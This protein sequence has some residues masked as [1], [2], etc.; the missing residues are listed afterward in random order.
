MCYFFPVGALQL[1]FRGPVV[2]ADPVA[3][4]RPA[5]AAGP[6]NTPDGGEKGLLCQRPCGEK[7]RPC[8]W[9]QELGG[10]GSGGANG[11]RRGR[12]PRLA[13][14][15]PAAAVAVL[16]VVAASVPVPGLRA[17]GLVGFRSG[18]RRERGRRGGRPAPRPQ[19]S[20]DRAG[21]RPLPARGQ[22]PRRGAELAQLSQL[23]EK[24]EQYQRRHSGSFHYI[25]LVG[26]R[27]MFS[28]AVIRGGFC[29]GRS[30]LSW[31]ARSLW[32]AVSS[33]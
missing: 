31:R 6:T 1:F 13:G 33:V 10:A 11:R 7:G 29:G 27:A 12:G 23:G 24:S 19:T 5:G 3:R 17:V 22:V 32:S 14:P 4:R 16:V 15:S 20:P 2:A 26:R 21:R 25:A 8:R 30:S 18:G 9:H 28:G